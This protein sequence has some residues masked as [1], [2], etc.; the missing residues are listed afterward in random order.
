[1]RRS[2][3]EWKG[4]HSQLKRV[5][6]TKSHVDVL[7]GCVLKRSHVNCLVALETHALN[8]TRFLE[9]EASEKFSSPEN[10]G[11]ITRIIRHLTDHSLDNSAT[12]RSRCVCFD[13]PL[14]SGPGLIVN[15][16]KIQ[17]LVH[18][19]ATNSFMTVFR[20]D[21]DIQLNRVTVHASR[22]IEMI[23]VCK[24]NYFLGDVGYP[25]AVKSNTFRPI[26]RNNP[27]QSI[28]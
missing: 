16:H 8:I 1:M 2:D 3:V 10:I 6:R 27:R 5:H 26:N 21:E 7:T 15:I 28:R 17:H 24:T 13:C 9:A 20:V 12:Q 23:G 19:A 14:V 4:D 11:V 22:V 25:R 18:Q